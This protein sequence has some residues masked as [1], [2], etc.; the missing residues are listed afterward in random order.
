MAAGI[1]RYLA[2]LALA[3]LGLARTQATPL[4]CSQSDA[5]ILTSFLSFFS[6][7]FAQLKGV[8]QRPVP[9]SDASFAVTRFFNNNTAIFTL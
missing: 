4:N 7:E 6:L 1:C 9:S 2:D 8:D 3:A 5:H